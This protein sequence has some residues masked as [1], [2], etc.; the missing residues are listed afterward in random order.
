MNV[1]MIVSLFALTRATDQD[2]IVESDWRVSYVLLVI[3]FAGW[4]PVLLYHYKHKII[5][6]CRKKH[7]LNN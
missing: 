5:N 3:I 1:I 4:P 7:K 2:T 6:R